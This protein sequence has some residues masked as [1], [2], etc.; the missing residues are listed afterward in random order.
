MQDSND[1]EKWSHSHSE[2][3]YYYEPEAERRLVRRIDMRLIPAS[4]LVYL[5]CFLD[6]SNIGNAMVLNAD[7]HDDLVSTTHLSAQEYTTALMIFLVSYTLF[8]TPS[9]Y[10]LKKFRPSRWLAFLMFSWGA[11]TILLGAVHDF[12]GI[13]GVRFL[14]GAFEAG[15]FPGMIYCLTFW[16][17]PDERAVR[18]AMVVACATLGGAFGGAIAFGIGR[19]DGTG[20]LQAWR[21]LF[22]LEGIPSCVLAVPI[23]FWFPDYPETAPW[24]SPAEREL[25]CQRIKGV[26]SLGHAKITWADTKATLVDWRL[27]LHYTAFIA[28]S[29][30]FSSISLFSPT[31]VSGLGYTGLQAQLF[32]VPPKEA[33][34]W[35]AFLSLLTA[36]ISFFAQGALPPRA[37]KARYGLLCVAVSFSFAAIPPLLSWLTANLRTTSASTLAVPLNVSI[38]QIGQFIGIYIFKANE[39][40]GYRTGHFTNAAFLMLGAAVVLVLRAIYTRRNRANELEKRKKWADMTDEEKAEANKKRRERLAANPGTQEQKDERARKERERIAAKEQ[41]RTKTTEQKAAQ[42]VKEKERYKAMSEEEKA[43][44]KQR[45]ANWRADNPD[46]MDQYSERKKIDRAVAALETGKPVKFRNR[47]KKGGSSSAAGPAP[48]SEGSWE[49]REAPAQVLHGDTADPKNIFHRP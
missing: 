46:K 48:A 23:F 38:G 28:I 27:Y 4:M 33:R 2:E 9:N 39:A 32:T 17:K 5:L 36:S 47:P 26:A 29:V 43:A 6:R 16:Y 49:G 19:M 37:F 13:V 25:A 1:T 44:K 45:D 41:P 40:P 24:L 34:S 12:G 8:E 14:L 42:A 22:I 31:I 10:M 15:L 11:L 30:P 3:V 18:A 35:G 20:G 7:T 21:W